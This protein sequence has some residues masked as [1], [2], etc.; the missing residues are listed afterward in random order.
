MAFSTIDHGILLGRLCELGLEQSS[1]LVQ[2]LSPRPI[3][4]GVDGQC[5][6]HPAGQ[7]LAAPQGLVL[8]PLLLNVRTRRLGEFV[9][10]PGLREA[11]EAQPH[12]STQGDP[13]GAVSALSQRLEAVGAGWGQQTSTQP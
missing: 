13:G 10:H 3:P 8:S 1:A 7:S 9:R 11:D 2:L 12:I 4:T 6:A 5:E